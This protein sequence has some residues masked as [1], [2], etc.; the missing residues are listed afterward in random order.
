[1]ELHC[2]L[3]VSKFRGQN[4]VARMKKNIAGIS[5]GT[6][7]HCAGALK[8]ALKKAFEF[9]KKMRH[10]PPQTPALTQDSIDSAPQL[11]KKKKKGGRR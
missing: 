11:K 9:K 2:E 1:V 10:A 7:S 6:S 5:V 4:T 3:L 8:L